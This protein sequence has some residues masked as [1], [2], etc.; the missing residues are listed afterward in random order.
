ML[1]PGAATVY[2][3]SLEARSHNV[4]ASYKLVFKFYKPHKL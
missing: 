4:V 1:N 2:Q 3:N